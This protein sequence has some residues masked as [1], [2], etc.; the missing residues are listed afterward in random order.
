MSIL[1]ASDVEKES[2][3]NTRVSKD[4][5]KARFSGGDLIFWSGSVYE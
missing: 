2:A 5:L 1:L 4:G 3:A